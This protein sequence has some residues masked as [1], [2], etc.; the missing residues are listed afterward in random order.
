MNTPIT[1]KDIA[2]LIYLT[3]EEMSSQETLLLY[4]HQLLSLLLANAK[5]TL[6]KTDTNILVFK[7]KE[8]TFL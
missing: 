5:P 6:L 4:K 2:N 1:C 3:N 8:R 7:G